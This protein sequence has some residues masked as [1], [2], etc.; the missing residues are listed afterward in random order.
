M[1]LSFVQTA[2]RSFLKRVIL[3]NTHNRPKND[4]ELY[5]VIHDGTKFKNHE[6]GK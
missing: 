5:L 3:L 2:L 6:I 1:S 4:R